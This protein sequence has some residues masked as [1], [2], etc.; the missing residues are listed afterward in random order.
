MNKAEQLI[1]NIIMKDKEIVGFIKKH[2]LTDVDVN[3]N[4]SILYQQFQNNQKCKECM[5]NT[6]CTMDVEGMQTMLDYSN[7]RIKLVLIPCEHIDKINEDLLELMFFP[8]EYKGGDLFTDRM[9][10]SEVYKKLVEFKKDP[11]K[12]KGL[13]IHGAF[14]TG[15]TFMLLKTA[16]TITKKGISVIFAYY[17]DLVRN[18][19]ASITTTGTEPIIKKLK[20]IDVLMLDDVGGENNTGFIRDEILA[21]ILQYRML[22]NKPTFMT[23]NINID[24]LRKHF[25]ET[26]DEV[27]HLKADR[28]IE[29]IEF[30]M[31]VIEI[32]DTNL[33]RV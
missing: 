12:S 3:K 9:A 28:V 5:G 11:L 7:G 8:N 6:P 31:D 10:R 33:R 19:K 24:M 17:P 16:E 30:M 29:R 25:M 13:Y 2:N 26:R 14:G 15:K 23:S 32:K 21:P 27:N 18:I 20:N 4:L 22:G 1:K